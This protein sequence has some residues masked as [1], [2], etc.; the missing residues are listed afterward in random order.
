MVGVEWNSQILVNLSVTGVPSCI[1]SNVKTRG[2][3]HLPFPD[4]GLSHVNL[5]Y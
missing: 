5:L 4:M 1:G 3:K 2:L